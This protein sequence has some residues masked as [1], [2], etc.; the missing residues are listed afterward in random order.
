MK[1]IVAAGFAA[2]L[3]GC[4][5]IP[6]YSDF[7]ASQNWQAED[8]ARVERGTLDNGLDW[9]A[10]ALPDNGSRNRV[11]LRLRI[12]AGS[13]DETEQERGLAHFV[14][15]MAFNGTEHF[16]KHELIDFLESSGVTWGNDLNAYTSFEETV[17]KL[18]LPANQ[19]EL[20]AKGFEVLY[21]WATAISFDEQE[22]KKEAP[23]IV[24]EWRQSGG[25]LKSAN[26]QE[27][28]GIYQGTRYAD[29]LPIGD[30]EVVRTA[31][32]D[33]LKAFYQRW[34]KPDSAEVYVVYPEGSLDASLEIRKAFSS[35]QA[36]P[37][38]E[39]WESDWVSIKKPH[40]KAVTDA[41]QDD[42]A[43]QLYLPILSFDSDTAEGREAYYI[44]SIYAHALN[45][46]LERLAESD[47]S[48]LN[49]S[50]VASDVFYD[51]TEHLDVW[52]TVY[53][54]NADQALSELA[55]ELKRLQKYGLTSAEYD[56]AKQQL[57]S[58]WQDIV[59]QFE[60]GTS[61][62]AMDYLLSYAYIGSPIESYA[63]QL[64]QIKQATEVVTLATVNQYIADVYER[65]KI[66]GFFYHP[67]GVEVDE[68]NWLRLYKQAW[69]ADV[70]VPEQRDIPPWSFTHTYPG[71][72][73]ARNDQLDAEGLYQWTLENGVI[74]VLRPSELAPGQMQLFSILLG[75]EYQ[76]PEALQPAAYLWSTAK[77]DSGSGGLAGQEFVERLAME[78]IEFGGNLNGGML[79]N[80]AIA[81]TN[82]IETLFQL[83][84]ESL[85][86]TKLDP[87]YVNAWIKDQVAARAEYEKTSDFRMADKLYNAMFGEN[88]VYRLYHAD[89]FQ[90][91]TQAQLEA[92]Q[93]RLLKHN[94]GMFL[95]IVGDITPVQLEPY[96]ETYV[97]G[98]PIS[99]A[100]SP[101][102]VYN[103]FDAPQALTASGQP[104]DK[105]LIT[106]FFADPAS[107]SGMHG[108]LLAGVVGQSLEKRLTDSLR[109][110]GGFT[111]NVSVSTSAPSVY[112]PY[113]KLV[114][115]L[116]VD[117]KRQTD[118][119]AAL[120]TELA[121]ILQQPFSEAEMKETK[122]QVLEQQRQGFTS[123]N[124]IES[125]LFL[126]G[127]Y[128]QPFAVYNDYESVIDSISLTE[129][130]A[131]ASRW[132][133]GEKITSVYQP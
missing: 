108:S 6:Y 74:V 107:P 70:D 1:H 80:Y 124:G 5:L 121:L 49:G 38:E 12:R 20:I 32:A 21:D 126:S 67:A 26:N 54:N 35:W 116:I 97:A 27:F 72:I 43:W 96:L 88:S 23:V 102:I 50:Y 113:A 91:V 42:Y 45:G 132:L 129:M 68:H 3:C 101:D 100:T 77:S 52:A 2:T 64:Q 89:E 92:V 29:R 34:Y 48:A 111:Y 76:I 109:E 83:S 90:P 85:A 93:Q 13:M 36:E 125:R 17:Y 115:Q 87:V 30:M 60:H 112:T 39:G 117:P 25:T 55:T 57:I 105:T 56:N 82:Q 131:Q 16:P 58:E 71:Q 19:P 114:V 66:A 133:E 51:G 33:Q 120:E 127:W 14:E 22:V 44:N 75:G 118:A 37:T 95:L 53:E 99:P 62:D 4:A 15:H 40:F 18:S 104:E 123:N 47:D 65:N 63:S 69:S 84:S 31:T 78:G 7:E 119:Q 79:Y 9:Y 81:G 61:S 11:E 10:L 59:E 128:R 94:Q 24:A 73:I 106:Y 46:R 86:E 8:D 122:G 130:N 103:G 28:A 110:E 41:N 98:L